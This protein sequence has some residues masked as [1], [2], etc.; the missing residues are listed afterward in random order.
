MILATLP[1]CLAVPANKRHEA[2]EAIVCMADRVLEEVQA[3]L[4]QAVDAEKSKL[5][6]LRATR[7]ELEGTAQR[8]EAA[9]NEACR[10]VEECEGRLAEAGSALE[11]CRAA[12]QQAVLEEGQLRSEL[13]QTIA[14]KT[15]LQEVLSGSLKTLRDG[16]YQDGEVAGMIEAV[17]SASVKSCMEVSLVATLP[18]SLAKRD[19]GAFDEMVIREAEQGIRGKIAALAEVAEA[20]A[21]P[22]SAHA[23]AVRA[24][25]ARLDAATSNQAHLLDGLHIIRE[26]SSAAAAT[27]AAARASVI[28]LEAEFTRAA[29]AKSAREGELEHFCSYNV[30]IFK[31]LQSQ[32]QVG[33]GARDAESTLRRG[34]PA[35]ELPSTDTAAPLAG[36]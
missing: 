35:K 36:A 4:Q 12:Q 24:E 5:E 16:H 31:L 33:V 13:E 15:E 23:E 28:E 34:E 10:G 8:S 2:Q 19:R 26:G 11:N 29:A 21:G 7:V 22:L 27:A 18:M 6:E 25:Q 30:C 17:T 20:A 32:A 14:L 1:W 3:R 9:S